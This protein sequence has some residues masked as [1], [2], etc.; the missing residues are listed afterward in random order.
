[1]KCG[2]YA[3]ASAAPS[4]WYSSHCPSQ[5]RLIKKTT[6]SRPR[7][8]AAWPNTELILAW[9]SM[10]IGRT[11]QIEAKHHT[12]TAI[13]QKY[14]ANRTLTDIQMIDSSSIRVHQH[15]SN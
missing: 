5:I 3:T 7:P 10:D 11:R 9:R 14:G 15:A 12:A 1:M 8:S 2:A 13:M 4:A 6:L